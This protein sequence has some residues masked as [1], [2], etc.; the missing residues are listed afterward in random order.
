MSTPVPPNWTA[1][2]VFIAGTVQGVFFR[3]SA[4]ER[5][6]DLGLGGWVRNMADGRVEVFAQGPKD[7]LDIFLHWLQDGPTAAEV[8]DVH[9]IEAA[10]QPGFVSFE[11]RR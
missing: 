9:H 10:I 1:V 3:A 4:Q 2:K 5:A 8:K 7:M 6:N 11:I